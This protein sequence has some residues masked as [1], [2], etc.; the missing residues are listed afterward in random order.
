MTE[1]INTEGVALTG[2]FEVRVMRES[3]VAEH[4][5]NAWRGGALWAF[6]EMLKFTNSVRSTAGP[7]D[8][9]RAI[10]TLESWVADRIREVHS[11]AT[12]GTD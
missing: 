3:A 12:N 11:A 10:E 2:E 8:D 5:E 1:A 4:H 7:Y 9:L 6:N